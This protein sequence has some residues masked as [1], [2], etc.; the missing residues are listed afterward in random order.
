MDTRTTPIDT[1][2]LH[3]AKQIRT[4]TR[5]AVTAIIALPLL[6]FAW[7]AA[8]DSARTRTPP[9]PS[10]PFDATGPSTHSRS[11]DGT[12]IWLGKTPI[13]A[14]C[15]NGGSGTLTH[16]RER[17]DGNWVIA[18][19]LPSGISCPGSPETHCYSQPWAAVVDM[20]S[21]TLDYIDLPV[22]TTEITSVVRDEIGDVIVNASGSACVT[23]TTPDPNAPTTTQA[24]PT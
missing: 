1:A 11:T 20:N 24:I 14:P 13:P 10:H 5:W 3:N 6:Y 19:T 12:I 22:G 9:T 4:L 8:L 2:S 18:G 21:R 23:S 15:T 7:A 17:R 16:A